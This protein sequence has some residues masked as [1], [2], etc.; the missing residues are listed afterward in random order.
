MWR[1]CKILKLSSDKCW[2]TLCIILCNDTEECKEIMR[3]IYFKNFLCFISG[4]LLYF[5]IN[6]ALS[7]IL[8]S[9]PVWTINYHLQ[10]QFTISRKIDFK[11]GSLSI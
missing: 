4:K 1:W 9:I 11:Y 8:V 7:K 3:I 10:L 5:I 6:K 2:T